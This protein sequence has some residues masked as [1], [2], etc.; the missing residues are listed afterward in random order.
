MHLSKPLNF[1]SDSLNIEDNEKSSGDGETA[2]TEAE[3]G[4]DSGD[5][6]DAV[7]DKEE[8]IPDVDDDSAA[9]KKPGHSEL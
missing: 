8:E 9:E 2:E 6:A 7:E 4:G 5:A 1:F 3:T